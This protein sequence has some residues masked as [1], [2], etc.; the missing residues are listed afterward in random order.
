MSEVRVSLSDRSAS[1]ST[2]C[3]AIR[4]AL[5]LLRRGRGRVV[6]AL[7]VALRLRRAGGDAAAG[8]EGAAAAARLELCLAAGLLD[9]GGVAPAPRHAR[10]D[11]RGSGD[12]PLVDLAAPREPGL[13][14]RLV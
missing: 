7:V 13:Q 11:A 1:M 4:L 5:R 8:D 12:D 10:R 2:F 14:A 3:S 6:A 9:L